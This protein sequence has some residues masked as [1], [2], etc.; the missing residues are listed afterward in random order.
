MEKPTLNT[1]KCSCNEPFI[2]KYHAGYISTQTNYLFLKQI[3]NQTRIAKIKLSFDQVQKSEHL[4]NIENH[5]IDSIFQK[6]NA[7]LK[8]YVKRNM[9]IYF[10]NYS[11]DQIF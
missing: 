9:K 10:K 4:K 8:I 5:R 1:L 2:T 7:D 6:R 11:A 3:Y